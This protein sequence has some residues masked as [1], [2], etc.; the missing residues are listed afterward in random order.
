MHCFPYVGLNLK[1][2]NHDDNVYENAGLGMNYLAVAYPMGRAGA[3]GLGWT[4]FSETTLYY[5]NAISLNYA[6]QVLGADTGE[7]RRRRAGEEIG[8][9]AGINLKYVSHGYGSDERTLLD[10]VFSTSTF[11]SGFTAEIGC[12]AVVDRDI[13]LGLAIRNIIP[14]NMGLRDNDK[15]F[16]EIRLGGAYRVYQDI[17]PTLDISY[18]VGAPQVQSFNI[19]LGCEAWFMNKA[20][21]ARTG[22]NFDEIALGFSFHRVMES[23]G[24]QIDYSFSYPFMVAGSNLG[25]HR[26]SLTV[27]FGESLEL[28]M[29]EGQRNLDRKKQKA[30]IE[31]YLKQGVRYYKKGDY[32]RAIREGRKVLMLKPTHKKAKVLIRKAEGKLTE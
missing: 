9:F 8:V 17:T 3:V 26:I 12:I 16:P 11:K 28:E 6:L 5:E 13:S 25:N 18:R 27:Q 24:I 23:F 10:P 20:L 15:L 31:Q 22:L 2:W 21:G 32:R 29:M 19:N 30:V 7:K 14:V 4:N 1:K